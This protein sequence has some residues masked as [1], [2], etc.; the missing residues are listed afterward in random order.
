[1]A[2]NAIDAESNPFQDV[3]RLGYGLGIVCILAVTC[4]LS[5]G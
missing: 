4:S 1:M 3:V 5:E 2:F